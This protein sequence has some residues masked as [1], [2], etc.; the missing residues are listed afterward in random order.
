LL[1]V[2]RLVFGKTFW[3]KQGISSIET[4]YGGIIN[5]FCG[6]LAETRIAKNEFGYPLFVLRR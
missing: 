4:N 6:G 3:L 5:F 2:V 1:D